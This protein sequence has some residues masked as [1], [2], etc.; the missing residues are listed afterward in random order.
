MTTLE[1]TELTIE[2][3]KSRVETLLKRHKMASDKKAN[4]QGLLSAKRDELTKLRE[5]IEAAGLDPSKLKE[6]KEELQQ[7]L[8]RLMEDFDNRLTNVEKAFASFEERK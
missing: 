7:D 8:V 6:K 4:Y 3:I 1:N 5:E 2:S